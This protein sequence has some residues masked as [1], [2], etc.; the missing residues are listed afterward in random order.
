MIKFFNQTAA[1]VALG[2]MLALVI[3][4]TLPGAVSAQVPD[5]TALLNLLSNNPALMQQLLQMV[6]GTGTT[7][8]MPAM[9]GGCSF[10][11]DLTIGSTGEDVKCLQVW[12]NS[13]GFPVAATG[14]GSMGM[15]TMT[16]GPLTET[17]LKMYQASAGIS[18]ASGY[19]GP[20]TR[21]NLSAMAGGTTGGGTTMPPSTGTGTLCPNGNPL[22]NNCMPVSSSGPTC[23]NGNLL[24]NNC[25]PSGTTG[26][27]TTPGTL[28]GGAGSID[29]ADFVSGLNSE[30]VGEG[31]EDVEVFGLDLDADEGSDL[32]ITAVRLDFDPSTGVG[33]SDLEDYITEVSIWFNGEEVA[34]IDADQFNDDNNYDRTISLDSGAIIQAGEENAEL[35]VAVTAVNNISSDEDNDIWLVQAESVRFKDAQGASVTDTS[36]GD[37]G[38]G[39]TRSFNFGTFASAANAELKID[40]GDD[41]INDP[42]VIDIHAS[43]DTDDVSVLS[44]TLEA[45]GDSD[46]VIERMSASSTVAA[47]GTAVDDVD[48]LIKDITLWIDGTEVATGETITSADATTTKG[49]LFDD[50]D[51]DLAAGE[52]V[53]AEIKVSFNSVADGALEGATLAVFISE[54][55]TDDTAGWSVEDESGEVLSDTRV[56]GSANTSSDAHAVYD[57]GINVEFVS[58]DADTDGQAAGFSGGDDTGIYQIVFDVTSFGDDVFIDGAVVASTTASALS[59]GPT[60]E[61]ANSGVLWGTTTDSTATTTT[62]SLPLTVLECAGVE[63]NDVTTSSTNKSFEIPENDTRRCTLKINIGP[64]GADIQMGVRLRGISWDTDSGDVHDTVYRFDMGDFKTSTISLIQN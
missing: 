32:E 20:L 42:H 52:E 55:S 35:V 51:Y 49:W 7:G 48:D 63:A 2:L 23:P 24:S 31:S 17:A 37:I 25:M 9:T 8:G 30:E 46:L 4:F 22:S 16:F 50:I 18:P 11:R 13:H 53:D 33:S 61:T 58:S 34:R 28:T 26:G 3:G 1:K 5:A 39:D 14:P 47:N 36:T 56:T 29:D 43:D 57:I 41:E 45:E 40:E 21:A 12:L 10:T 54:D 27:N 19:F 62:G 60:A 15:E 6:G 38:S 59:S 44:F 64:A